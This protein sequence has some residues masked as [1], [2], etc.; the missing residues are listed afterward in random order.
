MKAKINKESLKIVISL[1]V[2]DFDAALLLAVVN[3]FTAVD[4]AEELK[5]AFAEASSESELTE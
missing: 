4:G 5:Q 2:I 1:A 3:Y